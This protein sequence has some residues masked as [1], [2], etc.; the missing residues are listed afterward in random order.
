LIKVARNFSDPPA[1]LL[2]PK[3]KE[4]IKEAIEEKNGEK[5][6]DYYYRHREVLNR[7]KDEIYHGKCAYCESKIEHAAALQVEHFRPKS[8]LKREKPGD[9]NHNGYYWLGLEWSN[10]LL[11]CPKCNGKGGK[12]TRF[13]ISG[14]RVYD[15]SPFDSTG[16]LESFDRTRLIASNSPLID[17]EPLLL[18]PINDDPKDHLE[19]DNLGQIKGIT[20]RGKA[21]IDICNLKRK[22]LFLNRKKVVDEFVEDI[23]ALVFAFLTQYPNMNSDIFN[24]LLNYQFGKIVKGTR[25]EAEYSLWGRF[26]LKEFEKCILE[27]IDLP[28]R[29]PVREA[30]A[31]YCRSIP[32]A[33]VAP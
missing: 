23:R 10:L 3:C 32:G 28:F 8:G 14:T 5:C 19:F 29:K 20:K 30:F 9:E 13:P 11:S 17:E 7:L 4:K 15:D 25:P 31:R 24:D 18:H 27:R 6:T 16:G 1:V 26:I 21:T 22:A 33:V 2:D 12:G